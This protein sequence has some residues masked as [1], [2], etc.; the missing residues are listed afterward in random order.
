[1]TK[2]LTDFLQ[3][4]VKPVPRD[5]VL[6][7]LMLVCMD[8]QRAYCDPTYSKASGHPKVLSRMS[9]TAHKIA[10]VKRDLGALDIRSAVVHYATDADAADFDTAGGGAYAL[11]IA[12]DDLR[13]VKTE[14]SF[15]SSLSLRRA[16][17]RTR[18]MI[19][20]GYFLN[21]CLGASAVDALAAQKNV[22]VLADC[23]ECSESFDANQ[24]RK[25]QIL[26]AMSDKG[27]VVCTSDD[28]IDFL[29]R[30]MACEIA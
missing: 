28:M 15:L 8:V 9:Q 12:P 30:E 4:E 14:P 6:D 5:R 3:I 24:D 23:T 21:E 20:A 13:L 18:T 10:S 25:N 29:R 26:A 2:R 7:D 17:D 11:D 22:C 16:F 19:F 27:A 1:M